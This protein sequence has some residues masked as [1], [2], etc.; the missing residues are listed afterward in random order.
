[1]KKFYMTMVAMLCGV[2]AMA[3]NELYADE[4]AIEKG[5]TTANLEIKM[6]NEVEV[7]AFSFRLGL[8]EGVTMTLNKKGKKYV[9]IDEDRMEEHVAIIQTA[10]DGAD[11]ISVYD[12]SK[13]PFYG[14][15]GTVVTVPLTITDEVAANDVTLAMKVYNI[16][17]STPAGVSLDTTEAFDVNLKIGA[18]NGINGIN[19]ADSKAPIYNVAGQRVSKAQKGVFIQNGKKVAVK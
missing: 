15:D 7:T 12:A 1:M 16:S 19:A 10:A 6:R 18:G 14:N 3:Q 11:M 13:A 4:V 5:E 17:L 8:P 9:T 2:A